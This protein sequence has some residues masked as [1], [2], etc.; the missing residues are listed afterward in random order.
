MADENLDD[1]ILNWVRP[2][3]L[4]DGYRN[5]DLDDVGL[6]CGGRGNGEGGCGSGD[7]GGGGHGSGSD[8]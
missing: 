4:D 1:E 2:D 7:F 6:D 5:P 8:F 3:H